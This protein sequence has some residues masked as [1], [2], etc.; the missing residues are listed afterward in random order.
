MGAGRNNIWKPF[1]AAAAFLAGLAI[2]AVAST[3]QEL[4]TF[5]K[6]ASFADAKLDLSDAITKRGLVVDFNGNVGRMLERTGKDVGST[7]PLYKDAEYLT[8]CSAQLSRQ[9]MEADA[10]NGGYC[11]FVMFIYEADA[12]PGEVVIGYRRMPQTGNPASLKAFSAINAL[13]EGIASEAAK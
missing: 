2:F 3:A 4:R 1:A 10:A 5:T 7:K 11:P 13:L 9:M 12:R 8:F 6:K